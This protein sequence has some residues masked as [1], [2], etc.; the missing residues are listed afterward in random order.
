MQFYNDASSNTI[1]KTFDKWPS[2][3]LSS[4][5]YEV[6]KA[7]FSN[8]DKKLA[9]G[10][11]SSKSIKV[12]VTVPSVTKKCVVVTLKKSLMNVFQQEYFESRIVCQRTRNRST[13]K[14][15]IGCKQEKF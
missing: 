15:K 10:Q 1:T 12:C 3:G 9:S 5:G 6:K 11:Q 13:R 7:D 14:S 2:N 8:S 4:V